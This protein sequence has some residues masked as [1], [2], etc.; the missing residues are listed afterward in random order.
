MIGFQTLFAMGGRRGG[1]LAPQRRTGERPPGAN[2]L[3]GSGL[4]DAFE[5][6]S[7]VSC[8]QWARLMTSGPRTQGPAKQHNLYDR[9]WLVL[10]GAGL[11]MFCAVPAV[12]QFTFGTFAPEIANSTG[13]SPVVIAASI[14]PAM[15]PAFLLSPLVGYG[16]DRLGVRAIVLL[17]GPLY[18]I[19]LVALGL[20]P[21]NASQFVAFL[22]LACALSFAASPV[23]YAQL[24][25]GWFSRRR[26]LAL[27]IVMGSSSLGISFWSPIAAS[28]MPHGWRTAYA[29]LGVASGTIIFASAVFLLQN[30]PRPAMQREAAMV[31]GLTLRDALRSTTF[32]RI[33]IVFLLLTGA[34]GGIAVNLPVMLRQTGLTAQQAASV[35]SVVGVA[36]LCGMVS[37]GLTLD[38]WFVPYVT[39]VFALFPAVAFSLLLFNHSVPA[40]F[41]A[42]ALIG[43]GLGS[44]LT[45]A[46]MMVSGAFGVKAFGSIYGLVTL[47][48][49]LSSAAGP[50][51][52]GAALVK[53]VDLNLMFGVALAC[54]LPAIGLLFTMRARHLPFQTLAKGNAAVPV[55]MQPAPVDS[56]MSSR[57]GS[58]L[59]VDQ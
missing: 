23:L 9:A 21:E 30:A 44:E 39:G 42:A 3:R 18:G 51:L 53:S 20:L 56:P 5:Q 36:M 35:M 1:R 25:T 26:G 4:P 6:T 16:A 46:A 12:I 29:L 7:K 32:W 14:G 50:A 47:I 8:R 59:K 38:R 40:F 33:A 27:S 43:A 48:F 17:G 34:L 45:A 54:V 2:L 58:V 52:I 11:C 31:E 37:A 15:L 19:G 10:L 41:L 13:W 28:L 22:T 57:T 55:M 24:V 49:G